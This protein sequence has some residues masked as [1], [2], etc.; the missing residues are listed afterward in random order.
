MLLL[1]LRLGADRYALDVRQILEVIPVVKL[2]KIP[3]AP[4]WVA[5]MLSY[6]G[7]PTPV[8]DL[9]QLAQGYPARPALSS[10]IVLVSYP[11]GN[12]AAR[13][14]GLITEQAT[15]V[16]RRDESQFRDGGIHLSEGPYLGRLISDSEGMIQEI[17][18]EPLL[19]EAVKELLFGE[20]E[21]VD[22]TL[23]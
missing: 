2:K 19:P 6:R 5:G 11:D 10:R 8:I 3:H 14:L 4:D 13:V 21:A 15:E 18:V 12:G 16:V 22:A 9:C 1:L 20:R 7:R 23:A 17:E